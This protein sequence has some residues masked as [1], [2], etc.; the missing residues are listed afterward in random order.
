E[1]TEVVA[2]EAGV[3]NLARY[4][5]KTDDYNE[6]TIRSNW[7]TNQIDPNAVSASYAS[8]GIPIRGALRVR[9][10][11]GTWGTWSSS[12]TSQ[13]VEG[14]NALY[15]LQVQNNPAGLVE[16][17]GGRDAFEQR[18]DVYFRTPGDS[19]L[20]GGWAFTN[21]GNFSNVNNEP[22][23]HSPYLF[24]WT[25][26]PWKAQR[27]VSQAIQ[28][29]WVDNW[30]INSYAGDRWRNT[31][32]IPG[33]D[34]L[35][36]MTAWATMSMMGLFNVDV[37]RSDMS[38]VAPWFSDILLTREGGGSVKI[39]APGAEHWT[40]GA[41][42]G[43]TNKYIQSM[44]V[45][46]D[47]WTKR[48]I[49]E[50]YFEPGVDLEIEYALGSAPSTWGNGVE[51]EYSPDRNGEKTFSM[52]SNIQSVTVEPGGAATNV[53]NLRADRIFYVRDGEG[54]TW[55]VPSQDGIT[56]SPSQG[57][58]EFNASG[59]ATQPIR[60][61][62]S[63]GAAPGLH[64]VE[65]RSASTT[66]DPQRPVLIDV[67]VTDTADGRTVAE[68]GLE[69][70]QQGILA[71]Q[72]TQTDGWTGYAADSQPSLTAGSGTVA[73]LTA[74]TGTR[75]IQ[76]QARATKAGALAHKDLIDLGGQAAQAG[77]KLSYWIRPL[78]NGQIANDRTLD[79]SRKVALD[80]KFA[81]GTFLSALPGAQLPS[82][83]SLKPGL[84][85]EV[86]I[87]FPAAAAGK[88]MD[89]VVA[90]FSSADVYAGSA[91]AFTSAMGPLTPA[92]GWP[93]ATASQNNN[94]V[95]EHAGSLRDA[96]TST[97]WMAVHKT[98]MGAWWARYEFEAPKTIARYAVRS[99]NIIA[100]NQ[101][102][103]NGPTAAS[104]ADPADWQLLGSNDGT[105][106]RLLDTQRG[107]VFPARSVELDFTIPTAYRAAY[108]FYKLEVTKAW[109]GYVA[110]EEGEIL[111]SDWILY[112]QGAAPAA[113]NGYANGY[114]DDIRL[115]KAFVQPVA[116]S[117]DPVIAAGVPFSG[118][119]AVVTGVEAAPE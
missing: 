20:T 4:L 58:L 107:Q 100:A 96:V 99:T 60:F 62:A 14:A 78:D 75:S 17:L 33:N 54:A 117:A 57:V 15:T 18:L 70:W 74:R 114:I 45:N 98:G 69:T 64:S 43:K 9:N 31:G 35:G 115:T 101:Q 47:S 22:S 29:L 41:S 112:E 26:Q 3:A 105:T 37:A 81:D 46:G 111:L 39:T 38:V 23:L 106:W 51:N 90:A 94:T 119:L 13:C 34:D 113:N 83:E 76:Y 97:R 66:G 56:A 67:I 109:M 55:S 72:N 93:I 50:Q 92:P 21:G 71:D 116:A 65:I 80:V 102:S 68:T 1:T 5:G 30:A 61:T 28:Q 73:A 49:P 32:G 108:K 86:E 110:G 104:D 48:Y 36:A 24:N 25:S 7:W 87:A 89:K 91:G 103:K 53:V 77:M 79:A 40:P 42:G 95:Y 44:K 6:F 11:D 27:V 16:A 2:A 84:W 85:N 10:L 82:G 118:D 88:A 52:T 59:V 19:N 12:S 8:S 63:P